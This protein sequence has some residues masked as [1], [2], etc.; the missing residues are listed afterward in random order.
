MKLVVVSDLHLDWVTIGVARFAEVERAMVQARV[1]AATVGADAFLFLGDLCDPDSG[2]A[3]FR[4]VR[5]AVQT[6]LALDAYKIPSVWLAGNHDVIEDGSGE[7]TLEPLRGVPGARVVD[8]PCTVKLAGHPHLMC[9]PFTASSH[10]YDPAAAVVEHVGG[11][12]DAVT[13]GH[14]HVPGIIPGEETTEMPRGRDVAF[15]VEAAK[16]VSQMM[17]NGHYHRRQVS[18][19]GVQIVGAPARLTFGEE[20]NSPGFLV[21]EVPS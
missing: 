20:D 16:L 14:L 10:G 12:R 18:P 13:I 19:D 17:M 21:V 7:T 15:P 1:A 4:C 5:A 2:P 3:V 6:A 11:Q 8:R 9:L